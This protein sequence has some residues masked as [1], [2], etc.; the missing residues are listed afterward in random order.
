[1]IRT[2]RSDVQWVCRNP[3]DSDH[4]LIVFEDFH[5]SLC[6]VIVDMAESA[7]LLIFDNT[8]ESS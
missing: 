6:V 2:M 1:M 7:G 4:E 8:S 3:C 5:A